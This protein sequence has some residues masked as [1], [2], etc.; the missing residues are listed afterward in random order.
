MLKLKFKHFWPPD[1]KSHLLEKTDA[2]NGW[3]SRGRGQ[4]N[5]MVDGNTNS[6][7]TEFDIQVTVKDRNP[8]A[9]VHGS[10]D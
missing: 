6:M 5:E 3:R 2:G 1:G 4:Q 9:A 7:D 8:G 10:K